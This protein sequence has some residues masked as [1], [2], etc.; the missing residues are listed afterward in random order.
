MN[1]G[2]SVQDRAPLDHVLEPAPDAADEVL[3]PKPEVRSHV[4]DI[5]D[6]VDKLA[7]VTRKL[8][9]PGHS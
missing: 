1:T 4:Q 5:Q 6:I 2:N 3:D 9:E 7:A 8:R